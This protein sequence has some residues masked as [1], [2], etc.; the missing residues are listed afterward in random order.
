MF[1]IEKTRSLVNTTRVRMMRK[2][3]S[4]WMQQSPV[5][6]E[7][8]FARSA[9]CIH[10]H[11]TFMSRAKY[12]RTTD[13][14]PRVFERSCPQDF[15]TVNLL[16]DQGFFVSHHFGSPVYSF[17]SLLHA[18]RFDFRH[19]VSF[20]TFN[21]DVLGTSRFL[22]RVRICRPLRG[23]FRCP[24][25]VQIRRLHRNSPRRLRYL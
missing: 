20:A 18:S 21:L 22:R 13:I 10:L 19:I 8:P 5:G 14:E 1:A 23:S 24:P 16:G 6:V 25:H 12:L 3:P 7:K 9:Q 11:T 17:L 4:H 15:T 2:E